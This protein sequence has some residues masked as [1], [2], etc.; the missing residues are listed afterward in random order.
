MKMLFLDEE[1]EPFFEVVL[2]VVV[3]AAHDCFFKGFHEDDEVLFDP[4][5]DFCETLKLCFELF[6]VLDFFCKFFKV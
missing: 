2:E 3:E 6:F 5:L 1:V 4:V